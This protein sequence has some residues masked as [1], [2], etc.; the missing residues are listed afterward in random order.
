MIHWWWLGSASWWLR[1][2]A[3]FKNIQSLTT[4]ALLTKVSTWHIQV[5]WH[6]AQSWLQPWDSHMTYINHLSQTLRHVHFLSSASYMKDYRY[7]SN[8]PW[9]SSVIRVII[10]SSKIKLFT[11]FFISPFTIID[12]TIIWNPFSWFVLSIASDR[13]V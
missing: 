7:L 12:S 9:F 3:E 4:P 1:Q 6:C 2:K 5:R 13:A 11:I 10:Y 8:H